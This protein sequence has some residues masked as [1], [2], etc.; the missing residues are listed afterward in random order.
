MLSHWLSRPLPAPA[1]FLQ[2]APGCH[3]QKWIILTHFCCR[4]EI[5]PHHCVT[6]SWKITFLSR[7]HLQTCRECEDL[8]A[9]GLLG[10]NQCVSPQRM[11]GFFFVYF[12]FNCYAVDIG[13]SVLAKEELFTTQSGWCDAAAYGTDWE[14][15]HWQ[16]LMGSSILLIF[17]HFLFM[18][19]KFNLKKNILIN[20]AENFHHTFT[21]NCPSGDGLTSN[22]IGQL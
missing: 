8:I 2:S 11:W 20:C 12:S 4:N 1:P 3:S 19:T 7:T 14:H 6:L 18:K 10:Y 21:F 9:G 17:L 13:A 16:A 5:S 15:E 22:H